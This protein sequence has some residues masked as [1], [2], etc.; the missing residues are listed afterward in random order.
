M[1]VTKLLEKNE[2]LKPNLNTHT[3]PQGVFNNKRTN[4][5]LTSYITIGQRLHVQPTTLTYIY[6]GY[7]MYYSLVYILSHLNKV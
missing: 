5:A 6:I 1:S 7:N 4:L 2:P 3:H